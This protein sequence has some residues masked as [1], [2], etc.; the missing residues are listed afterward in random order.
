MMGWKDMDR[1]RRVG[2]AGGVLRG[3]GDNFL[4]FLEK[5]R[6]IFAG[7]KNSA[8]ICAPFWIKVY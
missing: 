4:D 8:Y 6:K 2:D 7:E 3:L 5:Y 1:G